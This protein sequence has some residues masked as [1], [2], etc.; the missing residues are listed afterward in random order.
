[1]ST[2]SPPLQGAAIDA[3]ILDLD[4]TLVDSRIRLYGAFLEAAAD[5]GLPPLSPAALRAAIDGRRLER[6]LGLA[7]EHADGFLECWYDAFAANQP[8][9][10][11]IKGAD[12]ALRACVR[13][14][15]RTA[16]ATSRPS[17]AEEVRSEIAE[18]GLANAIDHV[19]TLG[20]VGPPDPAARDAHG[21]SALA[22]YL[23]KRRQ[24]AAAIHDLGVDPARAA[25]VS[26]E[27]SDLQ[28]A[29]AEGVAIL[30]GVLSGGNPAESF[31][32]T[33]ALLLD[34]IAGLPA[35]LGR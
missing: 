22:G 17:S 23:V 2:S 29:A 18:V 15:A 3:W 1:V 33:G 32:G 14:G 21:G 5:W 19:V 13:H 28:D 35:A 12:E 27:G 8:A 25:M 20:S 6:D 26:D 16:I 4:G 10:P 11:A 9:S 24:I 31:T 7:D 34:S 30:V